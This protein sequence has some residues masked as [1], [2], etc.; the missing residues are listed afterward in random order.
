MR[1]CCSVA[2]GLAVVVLVAACGSPAFSIAPVGDKFSSPDSPTGYV[3]QG[4]RLSSRSSQ[5]GTHIDGKGVYID[6]FALFAKDDAVPRVGFFVSHITHESGG[7]FRP[8][9][10][11][12]FLTSAGKRIEM[13]AKEQ[14]SDV[15]T[16]SWNSVSRNFAG[17]YTESTVCIATA[18]DMAELA[19]SEW[20][21]AKVI[22][23]ARSVA[24][25]RD[26]ISDDFLANIKTFYNLHIAPLTK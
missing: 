17:S 8:I 20:I 13:A 18:G 9:Q 19:R 21:E 26:D 3:G 24:Y 7:G 16:G 14:D 15:H 22:G 2:L 23:G 12:V 4:N 10:S 11:V 1:S 25:A 6:P 5:G